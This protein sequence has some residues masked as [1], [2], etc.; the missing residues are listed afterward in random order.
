MLSGQERNGEK[1]ANTFVPYFQRKFR[2]ICLSPKK[3]GNDMKKIWILYACS[4]A[5]FIV[6]IVQ[7]KSV[8]GF[9]SW[10][11]SPVGL[12]GLMCFFGSIGGATLANR[13]KT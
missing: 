6:G 2:R 5:L 10:L 8:L 3:T 9:L 13:K 1:S 4:V 11:S 12:V 7:T